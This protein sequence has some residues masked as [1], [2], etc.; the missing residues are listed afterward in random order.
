MKGPAQVCATAMGCFDTQLGLLHCILVALEWAIDLGVAPGDETHM[1][2]WYR[3]AVYGMT[4]DLW[5]LFGHD[6]IPAMVF[7]SGRSKNTGT[8]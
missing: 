3:S 1:Q 4:A 6:V 5:Y 2:A 8:K 7:R